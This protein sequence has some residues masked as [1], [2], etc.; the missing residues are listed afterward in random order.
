MKTKRGTKRVKRGKGVKDLPLK[1]GRGAKVK[2]GTL[3]ETRIQT[4][5]SERNEAE[6]LA[7]SILKETDNAKNA[8]L[9]NL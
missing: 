4:V 3:L 5:V 1:R 2:G 7:S 6:A 9:K 8:I